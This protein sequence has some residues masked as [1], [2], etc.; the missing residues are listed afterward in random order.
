[1]CPT[2]GC[3]TILQ[4]E[5]S[6][7]FG[8]PLSLLGMGAYG[9]VA[10]IATSMAI[11]QEKGSVGSPQAA[12]AGSTVP[13][14]E[15]YAGAGPSVASSSGGVGNDG[16]RARADQALLAGVTLL[17]SCSASLMYVLFTRFEGEACA[18]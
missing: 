3:E 18:W 17:A 8:V 11:S 15:A 4:S 14:G 6:T 13:T 10:A 1:M 2:S 9:L 12:D 16:Q 5:Y 7:I